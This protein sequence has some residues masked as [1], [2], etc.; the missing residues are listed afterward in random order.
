MRFHNLRPSAIPS[1]ESGK[2]LSRKPD[3]I[4]VSRP[5]ETLSGDHAG[6]FH[7]PHRSGGGARRPGNSSRVYLSQNLSDSRMITHFTQIFRNSCS[8]YLSWF[9]VNSRVGLP[10]HPISGVIKAEVNTVSAVCLVKGKD[11]KDD[12]DLRGFLLLF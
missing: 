10:L 7:V 4:V 5:S 2:L 8:P 12:S 6:T 1:L 9:Q 3:T 11:A